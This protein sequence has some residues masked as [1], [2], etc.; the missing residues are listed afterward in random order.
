MLDLHSGCVTVTE[1]SAMNGAATVQHLEHVRAAY[2]GHRILLFWDHASW[3]KDPLVREWLAANPRLKTIAFPVA[4]PDL[5]PQ[6]MSGRPPSGRSVT[7]MVGGVC[8][9]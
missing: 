7:I 4:S 9:N 5:N 6:G 1:S 3:H 8:L 2:P